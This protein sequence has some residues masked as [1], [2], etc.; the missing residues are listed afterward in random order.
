MKEIIC[1]RD[2]TVHT[3]TGVQIHIRIK[4]PICIIDS[5]MHVMNGA[6]TPLP[7]L[8]S[9]SGLLK[10]IKRRVFIDILSKTLGS[11]IMGD[12]GKVQIKSIPEIAERAIN[13]N[14][15]T[16]DYQTSIHQSSLYKFTDCFTILIAMPMDMD[17]AHIL[18]YEEKMIYEIEDLDVNDNKNDEEILYTN[19]SKMSR[20]EKKKEVKSLRKRQ[21]IFTRIR[22]S[23]KQKINELKKVYLKGEHFYSYIPWIR[24]YK[25]TIKASNQNPLKLIPMYHYEPR[26]WR[27]NKGTLV[28]NNFRYGSWD[29]P[30]KDIVTINK[31]GH[32]IGFKLYPPL[33]YQPLDPKLIHLWQGDCFYKKCEE[34]KIPILSHCSPGGMTTHDMSFYREYHKENTVIF[35][36]TYTDFY[37]ERARKLPRNTYTKS[38]HKHFSEE[39][40]NEYFWRYHVHPKAW[41]KVLERFPNLKICLAHFGNVEWTIGPSSEWIEEIISLIEK[42]PNVYVDFSCHNIEEN[43]K[44]FSKYLKDKNNEKIFGKILFGTDWYMTLVGLGGT[45]YE[46]FCQGYWNLITDKDLWLRFTFINP[47]KFFGFNKAAIIKNLYNHLIKNIDTSMAKKAIESNFKNFKEIYNQYYQLKKEKGW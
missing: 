9:K 25:D 35:G 22:E 29:Q 33:G 37:H 40:N 38:S 44:E 4:V 31:G 13:D 32:F 17:Y 26:R 24:Q 2:E 20:K 41:R 7:L 21:K 8:W 18:G 28:D 23:G 39:Y 14:Q 16:F 3:T 10:I 36:S 27:N 6:C 45:S 30:F 47:F 11:L 1:R 5:H 19:H 15:S 42:Y 43:G 34:E 12:G 46:E